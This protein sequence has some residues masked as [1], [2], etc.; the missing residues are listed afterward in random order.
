MYLRPLLCEA[1]EE[2]FSSLMPAAFFSDV[3]FN[4][5]FQSPLSFHNS[6]LGAVISKCLWRQEVDNQSSVTTS[7]M[8]KGIFPALVRPH[9]SLHISSAGWEGSFRFHVTDPRR[10]RFYFKELKQG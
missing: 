10:Y 9:G 5:S 8:M 1:Q 6:L 3:N 7:T 2:G 4:V